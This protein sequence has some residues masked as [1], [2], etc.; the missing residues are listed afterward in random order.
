MIQKQTVGGANL[1]SRS[2]NSFEIELF[3][4]HLK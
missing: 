4:E 2:F 3:E 1:S